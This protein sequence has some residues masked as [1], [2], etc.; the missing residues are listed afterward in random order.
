MIAFLPG[1]TIR[2]ATS[3]AIAFT[4]ALSLMGCSGTIPS[5]LSASASERL[6]SPRLETSDN[7][8]DPSAAIALLTALRA[9]N[10]HG[11]VRIS[12][13]LTAIA[14]SQAR[15]MAAADEM[16]HEVAGAFPKRMEAGGY[17]AAIAAENI[18]AGYRSLA[19]AMR[20]WR[21]S[22]PHLANMLLPDVTE[23]GIA[24]ASG[25]ASKYG[26][27]WSLVLARPSTIKTQ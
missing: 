8:V 22:P 1:R 23:I 14:T 4:L 19:E 10:G 11:P 25:K 18:G 16:S 7:R 21:D 2:V 15:A 5:I 20:G 17:D 24:S 13:R 9:Q 26:I 12:P 27:Y 6:A 3:P